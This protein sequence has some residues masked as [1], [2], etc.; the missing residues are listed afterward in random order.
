MGEET[1]RACPYTDRPMPRP[2]RASP[3]SPT[4]LDVAAFC[5]DGARLEGRWS[6]ADLPRLADSVLQA[7]DAPAPEAGP[8]AW[9]ASGRLKPVRGGSPQCELDLS[10]RADVPLECQRCLQPMH[11]P[12]TVERRFLFVAG[13]DEA[14]RLDEEVEDD[15]L[16]LVP[17]FDLRAL[18]EDELLLAL[19]LVPRHERCPALP[20][21][22]RNAEADPVEP[23]ETPTDDPPADHPF[24]ALAAWRRD[25]R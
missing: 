1:A 14:A 23:A 6:L 25:K 10:V 21:G 12:L 3:W 17:R 5:R 11:L 15:V 19:P 8:V 18:I 2:H 20:A 24:A 13:E 22:L 9:A 7:A 16:A 4:A